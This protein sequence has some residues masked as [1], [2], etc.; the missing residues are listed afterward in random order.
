MP[1]KPSPIKKV[2]DKSTK[3][4]MLDAY[5]VLVKQLEEKRASELA[6]ERKLEEKKT[7]EAVKVAAAVAPENIDREIGQLKAEIGKMLVDVSDRLSTESAKFRSLQKAVESKE[8]DL[9]ELY[10]IEKAAVSLAALI[11]AQNERRFT[12]ETEIA[13]E[14]EQLQGEIDSLR[15]EWTEE[16]KAHEAEM[17]E[18]EATEKKA[19]DREREDFTYAFKREQQAVKDKLTDEKITLEKEIKLRKETT[20][21]EFGEREKMIAEREQ[22]LATLRAKAAAYPKELETAVSQAIKETTERLKLEARNREELLQ[23]QFEGERNVLSARNESL[24]KTNKDLI[25]AN[26]KLAQ[27]LESAYQKVQE[28]AEKTVESASQS[29]SLADLQKLLVD[30]SRKGQAE[31]G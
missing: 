9:K 15:A 4:E 26:S 6:P 7:E 24:D 12:F 21:K 13:K 25:A 23:K 3:Q 1:E 29:R 2:S 20:E 5:Q 19:R 30:Q 31:K 28:I 16:K 8:R 17:K 27:Q 14:R 11:E 22:E 18:R 10:G